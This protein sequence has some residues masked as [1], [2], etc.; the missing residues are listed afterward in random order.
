MLLALLDLASRKQVERSFT[1]LSAKAGFIGA[2]LQL[3]LGQVRTAASA[4]QWAGILRMSQKYDGRRC[5]CCSI[6]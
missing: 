2:L 4:S 5:V 6:E 3:D 1:V